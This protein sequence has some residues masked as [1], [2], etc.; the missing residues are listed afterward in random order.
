MQMHSTVFFGNKLYE[1]V[2]FE[3][4]LHDP[5]WARKTKNVKK[6]PWNYVLNAFRLEKKKSVEKGQTFRK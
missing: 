6:P 4:M 1:A 2:D 5:P 3:I